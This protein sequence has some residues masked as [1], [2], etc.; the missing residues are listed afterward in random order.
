MLLSTPIST[1]SISEAPCR[2]IQRQRPPPI[3]RHNMTQPEL[4]QHSAVRGFRT[5]KLRYLRLYCI[6]YARFRVIYDVSG[7]LKTDDAACCSEVRSSPE[8]PGWPGPSTGDKIHQT[9]SIS[10]K[11]GANPASPTSLVMVDIYQ[12]SRSR[13]LES[14]KELSSCSPTPCLARSNIAM[15]TE[16][17][18]AEAPHKIYDVCPSRSRRPIDPRLTL[19]RPF[20]LWILG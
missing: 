8:Q 11:I 2:E 20:S 7:R 18:Q 5:Q 9:S 3:K 16:T 10:T 14:P 4:R 13:S 6:F 1:M 17:G 19:N 15:S 12:T